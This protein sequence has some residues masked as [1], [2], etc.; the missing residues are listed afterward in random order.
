VVE[1]GVGVG[2]CVGGLSQR[3]FKDAH[4]KYHLWAIMQRR[5]VGGGGT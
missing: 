1:V 2:G 5:S 4:L 3:L